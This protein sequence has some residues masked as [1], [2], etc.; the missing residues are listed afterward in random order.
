MNHRK[1]KIGL[2]AASLPMLCYLAPTSILAQV[3]EA[4]PDTSLQ[5]IQM[6]TTVPNILCIISSILVSKFTPYM[7]KRHLILM[8]GLLY[9]LC[10]TVIF[11]FHPNVFVMVFFTALL[12][13]GSGIRVTC[14]PALIYDC[15]NEKESG[16]LIGLQA[17]FISG[18]AM[19]FIWIGGQFARND[20]EYCYLTYP[21][22]LA[23]LILEFFLLPKGKL[24]QRK[25]KTEQKER[26][27]NIILFYSAFV[28]LYGILIYTYNTNI[29][30]LVDVRSLGGTVEA[31]YASICYNLAGMAAGC[32]TGLIITKIKEHTFSIGLLAGSL[33]MLLC[34]IGSSFVLLC[35]GGALCGISFSTL[36]PAGNYFASV[37][38][39]DYNRTFC[40]ALFNSGN[41]L[42][43][44]FSP[45][46]FGSAMAA[47]SI[48]Q[49]FWVAGVGLAILLA[50][51]AVQIIFSRKTKAS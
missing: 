50:V 47:F 32:I 34:Y 33:G 6:L 22:I 10:G 17:G 40:I 21:L 13:I 24:S 36:V 35:L 49:R 42:G 8:S 16:Q 39:T 5:M 1:G 44:F 45:V 26:I 18:G 51:M 29:S 15:Y 30:L 37:K 46:F 11:L 43:Q 27:P 14:I 12:G 38:S 31:S 48:E 2:M 20:W 3:T 19:L 25:E 23:I 28:F 7:Y 41:N 4:F 9:P